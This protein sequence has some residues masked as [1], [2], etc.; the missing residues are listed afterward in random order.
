MG[1]I[2][3]PFTLGS[4]WLGAAYQSGHQASSGKFGGSPSVYCR[5]REIRGAAVAALGS[6]GEG[7]NLGKRRVLSLGRHSNPT[8]LAR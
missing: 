7:E 6:S 2:K 5:M 3:S 1:L 4:L 8:G